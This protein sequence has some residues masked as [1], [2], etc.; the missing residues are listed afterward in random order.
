MDISLEC[1]AAKA[2]HQGRAILVPK[3]QVKSL[4]QVKSSSNFKAAKHSR[5]AES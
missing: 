1:D 3:Q 5:L 2:A 4:N